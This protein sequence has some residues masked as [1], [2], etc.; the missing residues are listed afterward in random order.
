ME[1]FIFIGKKLMLRYYKKFVY[2]KCIYCTVNVLYYLLYFFS[3]FF[4]FWVSKG[5]SSIAI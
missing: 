2:L 5:L 3:F 1:H 4:L